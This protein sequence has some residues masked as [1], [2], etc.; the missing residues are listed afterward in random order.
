MRFTRRE[1][2]HNG[3]PAGANQ[4]DPDKP[5]SRPDMRP[6]P[7][8]LG[9]RRESPKGDEAGVSSRS[10]VVKP[11]FHHAAGTRR[12]VRGSVAALPRSGGYAESEL[13]DVPSPG[14][15]AAP[16]RRAWPGREASAWEKCNEFLHVRMHLHSLC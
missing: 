2:S 8:A 1:P 3:G 4:R 5:D 16:W 14:A 9:G 13:R 12:T 6:H 10:Y 7:L 11:G 15:T